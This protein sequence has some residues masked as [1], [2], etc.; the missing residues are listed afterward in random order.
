MLLVAAAGRSVATVEPQPRVLR[1]CADPNN[2]PFSNQRE[3]GFENRIATIVAAELGETVHYFWQPQR[4]G[5]V[6]TTLRAGLCDLIVGVP[7]PYEPVAVTTPY[8]RSSYVFVTRASEPRI[9]SFDDP[10]LRGLRIGIQ[11]TGE[12]YENPPA[13]LALARR[14]LADQVRGFTV[15]GGY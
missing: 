8:Y 3:E 7:S 11:L 15:F 6:R 13:A 1:V 5:F 10:R 4:R 12:D 14:D 2:L 9:R